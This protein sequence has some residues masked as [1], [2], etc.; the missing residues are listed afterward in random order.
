[1]KWLL[2][3][4]EIS[5]CQCQ[6]SVSWMAT[7]NYESRRAQWPWS[8]Y[9]I[10]FARYF[11]ANSR[12]LSLAKWPLIFGVLSW[13]H[14]TDISQP[15]VV[16][17]FVCPRQTHWTASSTGPL[18]PRMFRHWQHFHLRFTV[19][20]LKSWLQFDSKC[21]SIE[22]FHSKDSTWHWQA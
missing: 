3:K 19:S 1:M 8:L 17:Y 12:K 15:V 14:W 16:F 7:I 11:T 18:W 9:L 2:E 5:Y 20:R 22:S 21:L 13:F 10:S 6:K 4:K